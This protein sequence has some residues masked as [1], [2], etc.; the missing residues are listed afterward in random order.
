MVRV[1][2]EVP[3]RPYVV[4]IGADVLAIVPAL[5]LPVASLAQFGEVWRT[6]PPGQYRVYA[7]AD[8]DGDGLTEFLTGEGADFDGEYIGV[9]ATATGA[10]K[11]Q[12]A[13]RYMAQNLFP[14]DLRGHERIET[15]AADVG[16]VVLQRGVE[17]QFLHLAVHSMDA[18]D[19]RRVDPFHRRFDQRDPRHDRLRFRTL[20]RRVERTG[21]PDP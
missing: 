13:S 17:F 2:V 11:A 1:T 15:V 10:L 3:G 4:T 20:L 9:R 18:G 14:F 8:L 21:S 6:A 12:T 7:I 19:A 16:D 5:A